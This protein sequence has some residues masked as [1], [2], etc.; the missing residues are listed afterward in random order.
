M[1]PLVREHVLNIHVS[2]VISW[3]IISV[4]R[5][6]NHVGKDLANL[7]RLAKFIVW[8]VKKKI[9]ELF[10][11]GRRQALTVMNKFGQVL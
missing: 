4:A 5:S 8:N 1:T 6:G 2:V 11:F 10:E 9:S 3:H 7:E